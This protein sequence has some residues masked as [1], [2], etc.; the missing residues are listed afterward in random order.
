MISNSSLI[1]SIFP[2]ILFS[3]IRLFA[4]GD[5]DKNNHKDFHMHARADEREIFRDER[6]DFND[7]YFTCFSGKFPMLFQRFPAWARARSERPEFFGKIAF[8]SE[9]L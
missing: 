3:V 1:L 2:V 8:K 7:K 4:K 6:K 9:H 5:L